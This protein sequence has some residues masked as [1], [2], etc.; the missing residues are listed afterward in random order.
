MGSVRVSVS[1]RSA[2]VS[3][4]LSGCSSSRVSVDLLV[5][6]CAADLVT[7]I[8]A[9]VG[10]VVPSTAVGGSVAV[11]RVCDGGGLVR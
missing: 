5:R 1:V 10:G 7:N 3:G 2:F 11:V 9:P 8:S 4:A 6:L